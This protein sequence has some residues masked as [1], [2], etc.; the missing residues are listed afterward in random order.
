MSSN[1]KEDLSKN[2]NNTSIDTTLESSMKEFLE[3]VEIFIKV[4]KINFVIDAQ[5]S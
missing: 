2:F 4:F 1:S 3:K 5:L